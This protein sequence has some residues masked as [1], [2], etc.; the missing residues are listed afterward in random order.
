[1]RHTL[2]IPVRILLSVFFLLT[3]ASATAADC[4]N[5]PDWGKFRTH[6][7]EESGR[8]IDPST[9]DSR[10]TSEG[11]AYSM[12]FAL[13]ANDQESFSRILRWTEDNLAAGDL[14]SRLPAW[15]WGKKTDGS[16]GVLDRNA[17]ADADLWMAYT[18]IEAGHLWK[19][20][21]YR[22][23]GELLAVRI[24]R[25]ET[26]RLSGLGLV[27]LPGPQG[28]R[29]QNNAV[30]MNPSYL[31]IQV[32]RRLS[33]LYPKSEWKQLANSA[34]ETII[35]SSPSGF[36]P[37]WVR[38]SPQR[39]FYPDSDT[40]GSFDAIRVYLWAGMLAN[41][42]PIH[43]S[44]AKTFAP[45][46]KYIEENVAPPLAIE[47]REGLTEG[48]GP[49]PA[50]FSAAVL[51]LLVALNKPELAHQQRLRVDARAP[52]ERSDNYFEQALTLY[53]LG[54]MERRYRFAQDGSLMTCS[55]TRSTSVAENTSRELCP[56]CQYRDEN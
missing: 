33:A 10:T 56:S 27:L 22:A 2:G 5:W 44:L 52:S 15:L 18:L 42:D 17:A 47:T 6:F 50:G 55:A 36:A 38:Y 7:I 49:G 41:D 48:S 54:W 40:K 28:F 45:M 11:Q 46:A 12:F 25:E 24:L 29:L 3:A 19:K 20:P 31:P 43:G 35:R 8:V 23:L 16:W 30:R 1:M 4:S 32:M 51:P 9:P 39:G 34:A 21:K 53:S 13:V 26:T 37:N 14:T